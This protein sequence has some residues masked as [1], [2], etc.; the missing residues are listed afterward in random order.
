MVTYANL[1]TLLA[2]MHIDSG[3]LVVVTKEGSVENESEN[4]IFQMYGIDARGVKA[5]FHCAKFQPYTFY[6][7]NNDNNNNNNKMMK[8]CN[9][10]LLIISRWLLMQI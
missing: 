6:E 5:L 1:T 7:D 9:N 10:E 4:G 2:N 3:Y 8:N